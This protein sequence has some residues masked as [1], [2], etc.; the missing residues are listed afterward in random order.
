MVK[1]YFVYA[2]RNENEFWTDWSQY[3]EKEKAINQS[4][5]INDIGWQS[6]IYDR[7]KKEVL[8]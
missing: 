1:R 7:L 6:K 5:I 3:H 8:R 4:K 2:R